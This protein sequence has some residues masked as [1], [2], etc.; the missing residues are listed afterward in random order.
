MSGHTFLGI[1]GV[2]WWLCRGQ[3]MIQGGLSVVVSFALRKPP[4]FMVKGTKES[5][6]QEN[7]V[8]YE[9]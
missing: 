1:I 7:V 4:G 2:N 5:A 9:V 6:E 3:R 8:E